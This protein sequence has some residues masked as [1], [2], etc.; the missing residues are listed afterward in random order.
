MTIWKKA[1]STLVTA[2]LLASLLATAAAPI[3]SANTDSTTYLDNCSTDGVTFTSTCSVVADGVSRIQVQGQN[4]GAAAIPAGTAYIELSISGATFSTVAGQ[5]TGVFAAASPLGVVSSTIARIGAIPAE[6]DYLTVVSPTAAGTGTITLTYVPSVGIATPAGTFTIDFYAA[7]QLA[8]SV[9]NST[10][11][12]TPGASAAASPA[13]D[14]VATLTTTVKNSVGVGGSPVANATVNYTISPVGTL[15]GTHVQVVS[16]TTNASGVATVTI[17][18]TGVAGTSTITTSVTYLSVTTTLAAKTFV[19]YGPVAKLTA[20][21]RVISI[22]TG[23]NADALKVVAEDAAG[24]KVD[25]VTVTGVLPAGSVVT[26]LTAVSATGFGTPAATYGTGTGAA[27]VNAVCGATAGK[28][29]VQVKVLV[30]S[31]TITSN[32]IDLYCADNVAKTFTVKAGATA[33]APGGNTTIT[34]NILEKNGLPVPDGYEAVVLVNSGAVFGD[35]TGNNATTYGGD[36]SFTFLAPSTP[37]VATATAFVAN[38]PILGDGTLFPTQSVTIAIGAVALTGTNGSQLGLSHSGT[39]TTATKIQTLNHYVTWKLSFGAAASG[40]SAAI[41]VATKKADGT[42][43]AFTKLTGRIVDSAGN[44][45][46]S[47]RSSTAKWISVK[48]IAGTVG[49]HATQARWR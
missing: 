20:S 49:T 14:A 28:A 1:I 48:G 6:T 46:F 31:T 33:V 24:N 43:T 19:F 39:F 17:N 2:G 11:V 10:N 25:N 21:A 32:A 3:A 26:S 22:V 37:G 47:W 34:V 38:T 12:L 36:A 23:G 40:Q 45:Y 9:A 7:D 42:W 5:V 18:S 44:A 13:A 27:K 4:A 16:A 15:T 35:V 29:T 30:G 41:W 8:V